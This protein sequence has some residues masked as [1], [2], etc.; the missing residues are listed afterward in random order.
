MNNYIIDATS[1]LKNDKNQSVIEM[2]ARDLRR[3]ITAEPKIKQ[4][5]LRGGGVLDIMNGVEPADIDLFYAYVIGGNY[6]TTCICARVSALIRQI[7]FEYL[8][9]KRIDLENSFEKEPRMLPIERNV[10]MFSFC[11]EYN[12]QFII[13]SEGRIFTN[14]D[15]LYFYEQG[16]YE[17]RYEGFLSHSYFPRRGDFHSYSACQVGSIIRGISYSV[18][19]DLQPGKNFMQII[20]AAQ[21][22]VTNA[23]S[24][25][26]LQKLQI[27]A[28]S[29]INQRKNFLKF[30]R[31]CVPRQ[32]R[33]QFFDAM[34]PIIEVLS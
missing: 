28:Q 21:Y 18:K 19:R 34:R 8:Y 20:M 7:K 9:G 14:Q 30:V 29:K 6:A 23:I 5:V 3:I 22:L 15:A 27:Y 10:G 24:D 25:G 33:S 11:T 16:I 2:V 26:Y 13:N 12:S 31:D 4:L 1:Q 17:V 32:T